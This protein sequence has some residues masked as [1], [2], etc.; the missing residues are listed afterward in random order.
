MTGGGEEDSR[1]RDIRRLDSSHSVRSTQGVTL[2]VTAQNRM[3]SPQLQRQVMAARRQIMVLKIGE[4]AK[5]IAAATK[6]LEQLLRNARHLQV[7]APIA[8]KSRED[9]IHAAARMDAMIKWTRRDIWRMKC[10][11]D[12]LSMDVQQDGVPAG[13][14]EHIATIRSEEPESAKKTGV[15][16]LL[17]FNSKATAAKSPPQSPT[18]Q[19]SNKRVSTAGSLGTY[20]E[21][22]FKTPPESTAQQTE[23]AWRL[24]PLQLDVQPEDRHRGSVTS[25]LLTASSQGANSISRTASTVSTRKD[26]RFVSG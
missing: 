6:H 13:E 11:K 10:H 25:T 20:T 1:A 3:I 16:G 15:R 7:L 2:D 9:M 23:G 18:S 8:P 24:P 12:I 5:D 4:L 26:E 21:D 19:T 14:I 17:R 22:V